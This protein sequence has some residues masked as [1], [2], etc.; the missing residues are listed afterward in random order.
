M[1][2]KAPLMILPVISLLL[3][4][5]LWGVFWYP[6]RVL[7]GLGLVG[8]W[9]TLTIFGS[10]TAVVMVVVGVR[11]TGIRS[12]PWHLLVLA[13]ASGWCNVAFIQAVLDGNV[14]RITLLFFLSPLWTVLLGRLILG[15]R[16]QRSAQ[17]T[18]VLAMVGAIVMLWDS[19]LGMPW[20]QDRA[21]WLAISSGFGFALSNVMIRRLHEEDIW[22]KTVFAWIGVVILAA[23][24]I[25]YTDTPWPQVGQNVVLM[26]VFFGGAAMT[27]M[28]LL[29]LY[30]LSHMPAHRA[31][32]ILLFELVVGALSAQWLTDEIVQPQEWAGGMMILTAAYFAA[33]RQIQGDDQP[34]L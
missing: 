11:R 16:L 21:D 19:T 28:T 17:V 14:V 2:T 22:I 26:T 15:E 34:A 18:M 5:C 27:C 9:S 20:P 29:V 8:L 31:A 6:L 4:A 7:E 32:V 33:R 13:I 25:V 24:W 30:G 12:H 23:I 1:P 10:A 3:S